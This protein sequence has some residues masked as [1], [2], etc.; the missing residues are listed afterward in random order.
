MSQTETERGEADQREPDAAAAQ[1]DVAAERGIVQPEAAAAPPQPPVDAHPQESTSSSSP[2]VAHSQPAAVPAP[3]AQI[4][5]EQISELARQYQPKRVRL[6]LSRID[7][8]GVMKVTFLM[9]VALGIASVLA[10]LLVWLILNGMSV[11][12]GIQQF[13]N[14][15]DSSGTVAALVNYLRLPRVLAMTTVVA[16]ANVVLLTAFSTIGAMLVNLAISLVGGISVS[17]EEE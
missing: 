15:I 10:A 13:V 14:S 2:A 9:A 17:Y 1:A 6:T 4:S 3:G 16:V 11:F 8:W 7:P 12:S 5:A